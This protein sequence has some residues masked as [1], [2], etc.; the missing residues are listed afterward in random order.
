MDNEYDLPNKII[1]NMAGMLGELTL[2]IIYSISC[3]EKQKA[4]TDQIVIV[5]FSLFVIFSDRLSYYPMI[6]TAPESGY[7]QIQKIVK[8]IV[9]STSTHN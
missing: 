6:C 4:N 1:H 8:H 3:N 9:Q 5:I 7:L 2:I